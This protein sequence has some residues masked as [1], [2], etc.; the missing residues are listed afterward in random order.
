MSTW[1]SRISRQIAARWGFL[2]LAALSLVAVSG[3][4]AYGGIGP[5]R[6]S[7]AGAATA[8]AASTQFPGQ[9]TLPDIDGGVA[10]LNSD[11]EMTLADLRGRVV[12]LDFWT[13][14]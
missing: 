11:K 6:M 14:C 2:G 10:W 3:S 4:T 5:S 8:Q 9:G 1:S 7:R 12:L 13:L